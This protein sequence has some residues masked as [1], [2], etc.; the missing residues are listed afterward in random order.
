MAQ[1]EFSKNSK[2]YKAYSDTK[3]KDRQFKRGDEVLLLLPNDK[4]K[5]LMQWKGLFTV[6]DKINPFDYKVSIKGKIKT[7]HGNMLQRYYRRHD[8][9]DSEQATVIETLSCV[10]V[11]ED[12][13]IESE[14]CKETD[15]K[16]VSMQFPSYTANKSISDAQVCKELSP[17]NQEEIA[18][19]LT[20][21]SD[22]FT[23]V[24]GTTSIVEHEIIL[25]STQPVRSKQ[26]HVPFSL[27]RDIKE[28][29]ENMIK[30]DITEP[31]NSPYASPVVMVRKPDG[32]YRK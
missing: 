32:T 14:V 16:G 7:Y 22:V 5:L 27:K 31:C 24:P 17:E 28:E 10:S 12:D 6:V 8:N 4:N 25:T 15:N 2:K 30:L 23:D 26:Y 29:V 18:K 13:E 21:F 20:E 19:L 9:G 1:E 11:I 3:A